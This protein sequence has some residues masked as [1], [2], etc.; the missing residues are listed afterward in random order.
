MLPTMFNLEQLIAEW[1]RQMLAAGIKTPVPMDEL[2]IHLRDEIGR[3]MKSGLSGQKAFEISIQRIGQPKM[4]KSEFKKNESTAM[5]KIGIFAIFIGAII[6]LRILTEHFGAAHSSQNEQRAWL[7][8]GGAIIFFG[9]CSAFIYFESG[10]SRNVRLWKIIG[11]AY[12]TFAVW[13]SALPVIL[14]LTVPKFS[15]AVGVTGRILVFTALAVSILSVFGWRKCRKILPV[16]RNQ[17][18]RTMVGIAGCFLGLVCVALCFFMTPLHFSIGIILLTWT[19]A[20]ASVLGGVGY[21][22]EKA[23]QERTL[24]ILKLCLISKNPSRN[25][26]SKCSP[27]ESNRPCR[28]RNWKLICAKKSSSR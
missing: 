13:L 21:G 6:I 28:W 16:V 8:A 24:S 19:L 15:A 2:E 27:L 7:I 1:R 17:R 9:L 22:L 14:F 4:L 23:A 3:Q 25:G 12:S 26:G 5:K 11:I 10:D 18:T 20:M